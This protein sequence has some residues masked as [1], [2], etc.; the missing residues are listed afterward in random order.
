[1]QTQE[2]KTPKQQQQQKQHMF[3]MLMKLLFLLTEVQANRLLQSFPP[4]FPLPHETTQ[5]AWE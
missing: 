4:F 3:W 5:S 1:M 2:D